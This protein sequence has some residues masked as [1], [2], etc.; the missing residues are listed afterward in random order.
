MLIQPIQDVSTFLEDCILDLCELHQDII[1]LEIQTVPGRTRAPM[2]KKKLSRKWGFRYYTSG[3]YAGDYK[4]AEAEAHNA[5]KEAMQ[6]R[7]AHS[8]A[9]FDPA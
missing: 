6:K 8:M 4:A 2:T 9:D 3:V 1:R 5:L 7:G